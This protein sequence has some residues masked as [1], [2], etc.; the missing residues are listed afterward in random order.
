MKKTLFLLLTV[1]LPMAIMA[2]DSNVITKGIFK[3]SVLVKNANSENYAIYFPSTYKKENKSA[4]IFIFDPAARGKIGIQPF[5][6]AAEEFNYILV[7][8]NNA[9][10]GSFD[11]NIG[12]A[13]R[14]FDSVLKDYPINVLRLY[15]AG[16]S[17]G[18][19]LAGSIAMS[20]GAFQGVIGCG[21]SFSASDMLAIPQN[22]FSY[23]GFVGEQDMNYQEMITNSDRLSK[24][25]IKNDLFIVDGPHSWPK[26]AQILKGLGWLELQTYR[27]S[28]KKSNDTVIQKIYNNFVKAADSLTNVKE[29]FLAVK[30]YER[31][32]TNFNPQI[33]SDST[34]K[35][36][37]ELKKSK[38]YKTELK[39]NE[40]IALLEN[41]LTEKFMK[42]FEEEVVSNKPNNFTFWKAELKNLAQIFVKDDNGQMQNMVHRLQSLVKALAYEK[43]FVYR[44]NGETTKVH[45][46]EKLQEVISLELKDK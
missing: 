11:Q 10:N 7:C 2:Q 40:T 3:D 15:I 17:G 1:I 44:S 28:A 33:V 22:D 34:K 21:A 8:S 9:K 24:F 45:Y 42:R 35:K 27:K 14:L 13:E 5:I 25:N 32:N 6:S 19:R 38:Q 16:F 20:S 41:Q 18:A 23:I 37:V 43:A 29:Y 46:C 4:A 39:K 12:I 31:I 36:L 26:S 30:E